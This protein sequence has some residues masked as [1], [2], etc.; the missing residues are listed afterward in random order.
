[1]AT[2]LPVQ[3]WDAVLENITAQE[4]KLSALDRLEAKWRLETETK[5]NSTYYAS[6]YSS[7]LNYGTGFITDIIENLQV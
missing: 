4:M 2:P 5:D 3:D 7:W 6:T 1:M